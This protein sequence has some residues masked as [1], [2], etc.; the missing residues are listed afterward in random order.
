[1]AAFFTALFLQL[2]GGQDATA[3]FSAGLLGSLLGFLLYNKNPARVFMGDTGS[4]FL[5]GAVCGM[6]F[7]CDLPLILVPVGLIY[8]C[9][10][11]TSRQTYHGDEGKWSKE[12]KVSCSHF[13]MNR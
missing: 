2:G 8:I 4:L 10:L 13:L 6:A 1:M 9:L 11:Y 7:A 3:A 5:G 12:C